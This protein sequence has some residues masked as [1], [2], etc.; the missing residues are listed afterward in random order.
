MSNDCE[1]KNAIEHF[2]KLY[3]ET[4]RAGTFLTGGGLSEHVKNA[5]KRAAKIRF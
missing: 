5:N 4:S 1:L 3:Q 2:L